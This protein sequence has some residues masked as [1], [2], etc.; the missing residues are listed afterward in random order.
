MPEAADSETRL[1]DLTS[2]HIRR[3]YYNGPQN[4][5]SRWCESRNE[6]D[7][8]L[9]CGVCSYPFSAVSY[10]P[11]SC[12]AVL[13][14]V[15]SRAEPLRRLAA[16]LSSL[17]NLECADAHGVQASWR[18]LR[19]LRSRSL[20]RGLS[21]VSRTSALARAPAL[22]CP[23]PPPVVLVAPSCSTGLS[24]ESSPVVPPDRSVFFCRHSCSSASAGG[25]VESRSTAGVARSLH[26]A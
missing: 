14:S 1:S 3:T 19:I 21:L 5:E 6:P 24:V 13:A 15:M 4:L 11:R 22:L 16:Q 8:C 26:S 20:P 17:T 7:R 23:S 9:L 12:F 2:N 18:R 25:P 10:V